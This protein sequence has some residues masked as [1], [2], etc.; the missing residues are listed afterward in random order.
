MH[1]QL[2]TATLLASSYGRHLHIGPWIIV[3]ILVLAAV[4]GIILLA[5][6]GPLKRRSRSTSGEEV[7]DRTRLSSSNTRRTL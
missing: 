2:I 1:A 6:R 5:A 7:A 4:V 3:P